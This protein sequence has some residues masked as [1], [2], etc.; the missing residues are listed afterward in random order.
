MGAWIETSRGH[1]PSLHRGESLPAWERGLKRD[2]NY[3]EEVLV[4]S[5]P[6][7]E[8]GLKLRL[9]IVKELINPSLPA[10]ERGLKQE[11]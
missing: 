11:V 3:D 2:V 10:W 4:E 7:W 9:A 6:A 5:L 8:R 1:R